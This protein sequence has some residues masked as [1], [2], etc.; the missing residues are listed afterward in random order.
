MGTVRG[1]TFE[2]R[3]VVPVVLLSAL[4]ARDFRL[5]QEWS[6]CCVKAVCF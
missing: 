4:P 2:W 3:V 5:K 1:I 6:T